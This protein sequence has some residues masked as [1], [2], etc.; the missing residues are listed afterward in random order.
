MFLKWENETIGIIS[1]NDNTVNL[2]EID[3]SSPV[4]VLF[5]DKSH[6][7]QSEWRS[8]I[9]DRI[10]SKSRRDIEKFLFRYGLSFYDPFRIAK[11]TR[12]INP[13]DKVWIALSEDEKYEE[14]VNKTLSEIILTNINV[15]G[16]SIHSPS[17]ENIKYYGVYND[18]FGIYKRRYHPFST[19]V[20]SE[21]A[22]YEIAKKI[23][24]E[25]CPAIQVDEDTVFSE[26]LYD[27]N[28]ENI[29][30]F[31][32]IVSDYFKDGNVVRNIVEVRP[33]YEVPVFQMLVL[34]YLTF[35]DDRHLSNF[36]V[37]LNHTDES[38]YP[39][40]DNGRSLFYQD[41]EVFIHSCVEDPIL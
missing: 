17:G 15:G 37:K 10:I 14:I 41:K 35:Q 38:F 19:D 27:Y 9:E 39:L 13:K 1:E 26:F 29:V 3:K 12:I 21:V 23:G 22:V 33:E 6:L 40:Y 36:A 20:E 11:L 28:E 16:S 4:R 7:S 31:R 25:C 24:V 2:N 34:D 32:H 30:H 18:K 8:F 5:K